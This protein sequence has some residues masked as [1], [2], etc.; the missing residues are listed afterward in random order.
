MTV[1]GVTPQ[2]FVRKTQQNIIAEMEADELSGIATDLDLEPDQIVGQLNGIFGRQ[3]AICWEQLAICYN[4]FDPEAAEGRLLEMLCKITGTFRRGETASEVVLMCN[5][6]SGTTLVNGADFANTDDH[7][8]I[9]WTPSLV[10]YPSGFTAPSTG[11]HAVTFVNEYTG[12]IPGY[13]GTIKT[14]N[15]AHTGW[16]SCVNPDDAELGLRVDGDSALRVR[17][18]REIATIGS[19]TVRAMTANVSQAFGDKITNLTVYEN[20]SDVADTSVTPPRPA[21]SLEVLI[22]DGDI[23]TVD[24]DDLAQVILDTKAGGISTSGTSSGTATG[25]INGIESP[26]TIKF[27]RAAQLPVYLIV[28]LT[29]RLG[30]P[31]AGDAAVAEYIATQANAFFGPGDEIV[32]ERLSA[33]AMACKGVKDILS[34]KL[35]FAPSPTGSANLPITLRQIGRFSTSHIVINS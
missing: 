25:L 1:Y 4:S 35:G 16:N 24:D 13:A 34:L 18:E 32:E 19:A 12:P 5:L 27:T 22:F 7:P 33:F 10:E 31:Y 29:K 2:G 15:K 3:L 21:H 11:V 6:E 17:R 20:E 8:E 9:R 30:V 14:I 26:I 23:P 28:T